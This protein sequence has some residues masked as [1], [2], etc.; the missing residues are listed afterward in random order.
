[1]KGLWIEQALGSGYKTRRQ[2]ISGRSS[3]DL[4]VIKRNKDLE[5]LLRLDFHFLFNFMFMFFPVN[6]CSSVATYLKLIFACLLGF[7]AV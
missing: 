2:G 4:Q 1:M 7:Y 3:L 5:V 6:K